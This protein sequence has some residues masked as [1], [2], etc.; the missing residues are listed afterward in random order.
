MSDIGAQIALVRVIATLSEVMTLEQ[1]A[2]AIDRIRALPGDDITRR[3]FAA[4]ATGLEWPLEEE[5][6]A[7]RAVRPRRRRRADHSW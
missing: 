4:I 2:E 5:R 6:R 7:A 1:R 3:L